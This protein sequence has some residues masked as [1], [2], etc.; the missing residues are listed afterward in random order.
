MGAMFVSGLV[1]VGLRRT[2][3]RYSVTCVAT[4]A[5]DIL[6]KDSISGKK[7]IV[8]KNLSAGF[9]KTYDGR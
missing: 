8:S 3:V 9:L 4:F 5:H 7:S 6:G 2:F 1:G